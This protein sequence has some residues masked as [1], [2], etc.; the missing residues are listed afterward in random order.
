MIPVVDGNKWTDV[1]ADG[2]FL[3]PYNERFNP[4]RQN[5]L[6]GISLNNG[7]QGR[8]VQQW[9]IWY[10]KDINYIFV[11]PK[12]QSPVWS[13]PEPGVLGLSLAFDNNMNLVIAYRKIDGCYLYYYNTLSSGYTTRFFPD[14]TACRVAVDDPRDFNNGNSDV[15][16]VYTLN[17]KLYY[18]QQRDRYDIEYFIADT[19]RQL[20]RAGPTSGYR[21]K[22]ELI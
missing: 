20:Q 16:F 1:P 19:K 6:G 9:T 12:D 18:R 11:G 5:V 3:A 13:R 15:I 2:P 14:A 22:I 17:N 7:S 8:M 10:D 21:F 4:F